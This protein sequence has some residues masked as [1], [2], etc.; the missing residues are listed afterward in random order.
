MRELNAHWLVVLIFCQSS[1][2]GRA[3]DRL[4]EVP[5]DRHLCLHFRDVIL[6]VDIEKELFGHVFGRR[7]E[8]GL[9]FMH[10]GDN[11]S[12]DVL[13]S[14]TLENVS[15]SAGV[16]SAGV[17]PWRLQPVRDNAFQLRAIHESR[18]RISILK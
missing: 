4:H 9:E 8:M 10:L 16:N 2:P 5:K 1:L 15:R 7:D 18:P 12:R 14:P 6:Q 11:A 17:F 13:E 3:C